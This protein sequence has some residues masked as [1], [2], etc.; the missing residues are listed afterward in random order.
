MNEASASLNRLDT[1]A[2]IAIDGIPHHSP[3]P[4]HTV[5]ANAVA[6]YLAALT[7]SRKAHGDPD[8]R[9]ARPHAPASSLPPAPGCGPIQLLTNGQR[10]ISFGLTQYL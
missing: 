6:A 3:H 10:H 9:L 4:T 5:D 1:I 7:A 2:G 8:A